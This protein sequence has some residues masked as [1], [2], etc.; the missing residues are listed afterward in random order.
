VALSGL[1][2]D[3]LFASY[4][5]FND[6]PRM[7]R[8]AGTVSK[9]P[10]LGLALRKLSA[11]IVSRLTSPK[12]AGLLEYGGTL[13]GAYLLR[14]GLYMPW[15]LPT[16]MDPDMARQGWSDLQTI[17]RLDATV[18]KH[19]K[20]TGDRLAVSALE[21]SFYMRSQLLRD[22]DWASMAHS[23]EIRVPL[24][25]IPLLETAASLFTA[26]PD[27]T[28]AE[29]VAA[30]APMLPPTLLNRP[31]TGFTIPVREWITQAPGADNARG[32]RGWASQIM[33]THVASH[34]L[35]DS[36]QESGSIVW[37]S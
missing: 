10:G 15:E 31:K 30:A 32:L 12:Y 29:V 20:G 2:G 19:P 11:P 18:A 37:A 23:L 6:I 35:S 9:V 13:G 4:P 33:K 27:L 3:E 25:D 24:L 26:H 7:V 8:L 36:N 22:T 17:A 21:M 5:S 16:V 1:G 34:W 28:K 14:R